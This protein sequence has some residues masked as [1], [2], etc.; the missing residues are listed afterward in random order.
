MSRPSTAFETARHVVSAANAPGTY[1]VAGETELLRLSLEEQTV[2]PHLLDESLE[3]AIASWVIARGGRRLNLNERQRSLAPA[4]LDRDPVVP[5]RRLISI[6]PSNAEIVGALGAAPLLVGVE[7]SSDYPPEVLGL[8]RLGPDLAVDMAALAALQP[9]LVL[10][11]LSVPGMERNI[12][13]L[14]RLGLPLLVLAPQTLDDICG[15]VLRVGRALRM[16]AQAR[17]V[18]DAMRATLARLDAQRRGQPPVPVYLEWWPKPMFTPGDRCWS[19]EM[20]AL[21]GGVNVFRDRVGQ[22]VEVQPA[23][24]AAADPQ[25]IFLS[26]CGVPTDKLNPRRVATRDG[27]QNVAAV[28][29][30]RVVPIDESLLGRPGPRVIEGIA[31]MAEVIRQARG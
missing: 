28:R 8:P 6:A 1:R 9:D 30:G 5:V 27:L 2:P 20:I 4:D 11:S 17:Q 23:D 22:S 16:E 15:D 7:S 25:V 19:N 3:R 12:A 13:G 24:V 14:D 10:A 18:A 29:A 31:R 21:A 26:W